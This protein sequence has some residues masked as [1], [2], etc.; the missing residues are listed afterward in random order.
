MIENLECKNSPNSIVRDE[1]CH[2]AMHKLRTR[3]TDIIGISEGLQA[4]IFGHITESQANLLSVVE[5][6]GY[7]VLSIFS[8]LSHCNPIDP[9]A[10]AEDSAH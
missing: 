4:G 10:T 6:S 8:E 1:R 2:L 7:E 3:L 9:C 5:Q